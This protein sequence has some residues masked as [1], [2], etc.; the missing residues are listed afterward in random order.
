LSIQVSSKLHH[1]NI[2]CNVKD[3]FDHR[4]IERLAQHIASQSQRIKVDAEQ[5]E[6]TGTFNLLPIQKW[7]FE[8]IDT[9][10]LQQ[11]HHWNQSFLVK[12]P[13]LSAEQLSNLLP[14]LVSQHDLLRAKY[15]QHAFL[16]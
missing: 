3:I 12:V 13:Q 4:T 11:Y 7:F 14:E 6:L 16:G 9:G 1:Q 5:G 10:A 2:P 8:G 15:I